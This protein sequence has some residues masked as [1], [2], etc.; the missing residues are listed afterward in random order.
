MREM[1]SR[2]GT[3]QPIRRHIHG[4]IGIEEQQRFAVWGIDSINNGKFKA[5]HDN[6]QQFNLTWTLQIIFSR[7]IPVGWLAAVWK[8]AA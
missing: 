2:R 3:R 8:A 5:G 7:L 4:V 6:L 1:T